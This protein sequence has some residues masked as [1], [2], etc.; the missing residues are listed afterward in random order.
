MNLQ[1]L[2]VPEHPPPLQPEKVEPGAAD[3]VSVTELPK[4]KVAT[5]FVAGVSGTSQSIADGLLITV[6]FPVPVIITI[7]WG[8]GTKLPVTS[9]SEVMSST[10]FALPEQSPLQA[11]KWVPDCP[12]GGMPVRV[13]DVPV[14]KL[15]E[16]FPELLVQSIPAGELTISPPAL[17]PVTFT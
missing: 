6:P 10:Q 16:Q 17:F 4:G 2:P 13:T 9:L 8:S 5:Q 3:A 1:V 11:D 12:V 15:A 7:S 14:E